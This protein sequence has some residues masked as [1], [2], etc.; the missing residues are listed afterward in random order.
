MQKIGG[1]IRTLTHLLQRAAT[2]P[3]TYIDATAETP[4]PVSDPVL[5]NRQWL[6][7]GK[8]TIGRELQEP[9]MFL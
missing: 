9:V 4:C 2:F 1:H 8:Q 5:I 7:Q 3:Q 6:I